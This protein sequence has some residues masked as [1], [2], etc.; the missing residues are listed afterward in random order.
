MT[1][2]VRFKHQANT[3][4][5]TLIQSDIIVH[6]GDMFDGARPSGMAV[7]NADQVAIS[8]ARS[9]SEGA[10]PAPFLRLQARIVDENS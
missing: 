5:G 6:D 8:T 2:W 4:F 7:C 3:G 10:G 9:S 1:N